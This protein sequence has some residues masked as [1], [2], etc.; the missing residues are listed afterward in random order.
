MLTGVDKIPC[1]HVALAEMLE[2]THS[3]AY[4][5]KQKSKIACANF[6]FFRL[7]RS[8]DYVCAGIH[9]GS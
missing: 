9:P 6:L 7:S 8:L 3:E 1:A 5:W 4:F 2:S